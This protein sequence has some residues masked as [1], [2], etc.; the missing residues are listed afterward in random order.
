[1]ARL[2][3]V[4]FASVVGIPLAALAGAGTYI[5]V[6]PDR[7]VATYNQGLQLAS[8]GQI[9][10]SGRLLRQRPFT[11]ILRL[12]R[13]DFNSVALRLAIGNFDA[14]LEEFN[15]LARNRRGCRK[16]WHT[17][18]TALTKKLTPVAAIPWYE[19]AIDEGA[20]SASIYNNLGASYINARPSLPRTEQFRRAEDYLNKALTLDPNSKAAQLNLVMCVTLASKLDLDTDPWRVWRIASAV[21]KGNPEDS[22]VKT[23]VV[24]WYRAVNASAPD[25]ANRTLISAD[26]KN[27]REAFAD[28]IRTADIAHKRQQTRKLLLI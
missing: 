8:C 28:L 16:A 14:A 19:R 3:P 17:W 2:R 22:D 26:E 11:A 13:P 21:L 5:A 12:H 25:F 1:M 7:Y 18:A 6:Q 9:R 24:A 20:N 23:E 10:R 4:L 15:Q 27:A